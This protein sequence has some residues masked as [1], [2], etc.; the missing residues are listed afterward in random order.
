[1]SAM[2][3][4]PILRVPATPLTSNVIGS[5]STEITSPINFAMSAIGTPSLPL[6]TASIAS[7]LSWTGLI[8][9][10]HPHLPVSLQDVSWNVSECDD[11]VSDDACPV[12]ASF[13]YVP[14]EQAVARP[15]V[16]IF[17]NPARTEN[18]AGADFEQ[19]AF[20]FI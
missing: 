13:R 2:M 14:S 10:V 9:D 15:V 1:M 16:R 6:Q 3:E 5:C 19:L 20:N 4:G 18:I 11:T 7:F 12:D 17:A 8:V